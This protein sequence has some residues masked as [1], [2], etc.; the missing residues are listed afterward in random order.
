[1]D[2]LISFKVLDSGSQGFARENHVWTDIQAHFRRT[3]WNLPDRSGVLTRISRRDGGC[4][5]TE[6]GKYDVTYQHE[7]MG[8]FTRTIEI[9]A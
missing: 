7:T 9:M 5:Y 1:M 3:V 2:N 8:D 6:P 4:C